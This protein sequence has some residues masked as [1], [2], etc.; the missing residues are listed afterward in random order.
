MTK[1]MFDVNKSLAEC[2]P[3]IYY[4]QLGTDGEPLFPGIR[5]VKR[6]VLNRN[7]VSY[8]MEDQIRGEDAGEDRTAAVQ[9]SYSN[10]GFLN[11]KIP[12]AIIVDPNDSKRFLGKVGFGRDE[13]QENLNWETSI[14]DVIEYN[15]PIDLE[16]FTINSNDDLDHV[17]AFPNTKTTILK[18]VIN[19]IDKKLVEDDDAAILVYLKRIARSKPQ[20]HGTILST[21]R[22]EHI[23][24]WPTMKAFSTA[25]AK[26]E[27][28]LLGLPYE[29][30]KNKNI[31]SLGYARKITSLKNFFWD[32]MTLSE[33]Y[34]W[35]KIYLSTWVDEPNPQSLSTDRK[36]IKE[37]FDKMED[38]FNI[39]ISHYLDMP[40][41][42]VRERGEGKF[43]LIFN[44]F[45][46]QDKQKQA[47]DGGVPKEVDLVD[48][49]GNPWKRLD[50]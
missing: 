4:S 11:S 19:A 44:G 30:N 27:S 34:G 41:T 1:I 10:L 50:V 9:G 8:R 46:A 26:K 17:P 37:N 28:I 2:P 5:F 45:F 16:A 22:K 38:T 29:G 23:S 21:I 48:E 13:A 3:E 32:G 40:I 31:T 18:S 14:Y 12:Q 43:P 20:W 6:I 49:D 39:W 15:K 35:K 7:L 33:K 42:E 47:N 36:E 24:R 25:R